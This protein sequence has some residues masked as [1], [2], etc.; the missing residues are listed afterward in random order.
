MFQGRKPIKK[1]HLFL[2]NFEDIFYLESKSHHIIGTVCIYI[3]TF[4]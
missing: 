2:N 3:F 1:V 4:S